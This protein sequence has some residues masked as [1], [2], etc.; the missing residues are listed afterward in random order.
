ML[1]C[2]LWM[3]SD[4]LHTQRH[5]HTTTEPFLGSRRESYAPIATAVNCCSARPTTCGLP[6]Q[7]ALTLPQYQKYPISKRPDRIAGRTHVG[8]M[9]RDS[10][11]CWVANP[12]PQQV[13]F[14]VGEPCQRAI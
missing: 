5:L 6:I 14:A 1:T 9:A 8:R 11:K 10:K 13:E 4:R 12:I 2:V 3:L 7:E